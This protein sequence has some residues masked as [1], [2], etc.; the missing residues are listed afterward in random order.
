MELPDGRNIKAL[1]AIYGLKQSV[2]GWHKQF[3]DVIIMV[4]GRAA[5]TVNAL[6]LLE[7]TTKK[8]RG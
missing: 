8:G 2:S 6:T 4:G 3:R 1:N 7:T 5:S